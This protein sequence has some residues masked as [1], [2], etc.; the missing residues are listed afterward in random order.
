MHL[1]FAPHLFD[2]QIGTK[3]N[4]VDPLWC[5]PGQ[6]KVLARDRHTFGPPIGGMTK[7]VV[8][9]KEVSMI[10]MSFSKSSGP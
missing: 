3:H 5:H 6:Q 1:P 8:S 2:E 10:V 7:S 9:L 4:P